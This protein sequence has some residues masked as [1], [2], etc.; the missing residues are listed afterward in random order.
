M[1]NLPGE[2]D[3]EEFTGTRFTDDKDDSQDL[4]DEEDGVLLSSI[5]KKSDRILKISMEM[6]YI[7]I[8]TMIMLP[9]PKSTKRTLQ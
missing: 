4:H 9:H 8:E 2:S 7:T 1:I 5:Q 3:F 6:N